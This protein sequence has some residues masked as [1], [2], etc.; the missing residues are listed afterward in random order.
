MSEYSSLC[1]NFNMKLKNCIIIFTIFTIFTFIGFATAQDLRNVSEPKNPQTCASL[2]ASGSEDTRTIQKALDSCAKGKAVALSSGVFHSGPLVVPSGVSLLVDAGV[3]LKALT[4]P[5]LYDLGSKKCGTL[6][7]YGL[8]CTAFITIAK[9]S[10]SGIYGKGTIDGQGDVVMTGK[11]QTWWELAHVAM[12]QGTYQN[13]PRLIQINDSTDITLYQ[14]TLKNSPYWTVYITN[15]NGLTAWGLTILAPASARNTD[16][17][18]PVGSQNVTIAH[19]HVSIGDDNVGIS[20]VT[21]PARHISVVHNHFDHGNGL[22]IGSGTD[23]GV[24]DV[25]VSGLTFNGSKNGVHIKTNTYRGGVV[26][27][28][29]YENLCVCG[30]V[31]SPIHVEMKYMHQ[32]G[33]LVPEVYNISIT[34]MWVLTKGKYIFRG[35]SRSNEVRLNLTDVH[36]MKGSTWKSRYAKI[37]GAVADDADTKKQCG[38]SGNA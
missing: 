32:T 29:S 36:I 3:T 38:Y 26:T 19:C 33:N 24:S 8:G 37:S 25:F 21:A 15:T 22:S 6:D 9:A 20:A 4:D 30:G 10:G 5:A 7:E 1:G 35:L 34:N 2:T 13:N 16:G 14:I 23:H 28:V 12:V 27:R 17:I 11:N 18:D 31:R